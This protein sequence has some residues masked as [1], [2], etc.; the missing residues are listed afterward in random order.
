MRTNV[1]GIMNRDTVAI[2]SVSASGAGIVM[3]LAGDGDADSRTNFD[4]SAV[5]KYYCK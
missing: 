4:W 1:S 2:F 3:S 5:N